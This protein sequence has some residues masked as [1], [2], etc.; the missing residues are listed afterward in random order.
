MDAAA[1]AAAPPPTSAWAPLRNRVFAVLWGATLV[2]NIGTWMRDVGAGW[3]MTDLSPSPGTV[4]LVQAAKALA[5]Y[6]LEARHLRAFKTSADR[7]AGLIAQIANPVAR[8]GDAG[9]A[10]RAAELVR[11][12][13]ALSVTFHTQLVKAAVKDAV[14]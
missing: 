12:L 8:G 1:T 3:L 4:A 9:A 2:G 10:E 13:A 11:E 14:R 6:G 7:E 5:E